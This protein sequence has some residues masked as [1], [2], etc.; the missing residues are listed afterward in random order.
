[1]SR[2]LVV[3]LALVGLVAG[4]IAAWVAFANLAWPTHDDRPYLR[5]EHR[6]ALDGPWR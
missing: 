5:P 6:R 4:A 1:M 3:L 2:P